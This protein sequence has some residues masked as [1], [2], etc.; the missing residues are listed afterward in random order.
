VM[1][2]PVLKCLPAAALAV[3]LAL[4]GCVGITDPATNVGQ[5]T[6][7][8]NAH[9][10]TDDTSAHFYFRYANQEADL[11]TATA[12]RTPTRTIPAHRPDNGEFGYFGE[13]VTGLSPGRNYFFELCGGDDKPGAPDWCGGRQRFFTNPSS[14][15]D[16]VVGSMFA[17]FGPY[18]NQ[19]V[20]N[21]ASGP[22]GQNADGWFQFL[23]RNG[24]GSYEARVTCLHVDGHRATVGEV[25]REPDGSLIGTVWTVTDDGP[26]GSGSG[27]I[28]SI[29]L[30]QQLPP[31]C[32]NASFDNQTA[33]VSG[34]VVVHDAP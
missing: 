10:R 1:R 33:A 13:N 15:Q 19:F 11:P 22:Q 32:A 16:S 26:S 18:F 9:G 21:A 30:V 17:G 7:R 29:N 27:R 34:S 20:F 2:L 14:S 25:R 5:T 3:G 31:D 12:K 4:T 6:A 23:Y 28:N 24:G 8:L